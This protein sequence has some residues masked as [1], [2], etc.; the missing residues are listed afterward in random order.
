[1]DG[2]KQM[3]INC[4]IDNIEDFVEREITPQIRVEE[5]KDRQVK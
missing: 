4:K 2:K 3:K 5:T 1:L